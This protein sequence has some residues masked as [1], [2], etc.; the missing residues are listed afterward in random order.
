[1]LSLFSALLDAMILSK[2]ADVDGKK[3]VG[4]VFVEGIVLCALILALVVV[5]MVIGSL[6]D[7]RN[8]F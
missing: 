8:W 6:T 2:S 7:P 4:R 5:L 3:T 1:M